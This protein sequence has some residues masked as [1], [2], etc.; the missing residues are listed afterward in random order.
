MEGHGRREK[1]VEGYGRPWKVG[2]HRRDADHI[3]RTGDRREEALA[4][5]P[6]VQ[7]R[8][9]ATIPLQGGLHRSELVPR[10]I[11]FEV[12]V[13]SEGM[14][15]A[16]DRATGPVVSRVDGAGARLLGEADGSGRK[17]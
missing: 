2:E 14:R 15:R 7:E 4:P 17:A 13:H 6:L 10:R 12:G 1:S 5:L 11:G 8:E 16:D 9:G 3:H